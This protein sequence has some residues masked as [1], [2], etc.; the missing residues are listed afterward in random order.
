MTTPKIVA[1]RP[2]KVPPKASSFLQ[3]VS[4]QAEEFM[5]SDLARSGLIPEDLKSY[6]HGQ[7]WVPREAECG[8]VIPYFYPDGQPIVDAERYPAMY[9]VRLKPKPNLPCPRYIQ[10]SKETLLGHGLPSNTPYFPPYERAGN[11]LVICEGEKKTIAAIKHLD[12]P[13]IGIGGCT[14]WNHEWIFEAAKDKHVLIVPDADV[15]RYDIAKQ[16]GSLAAELQRRG[17]TVEIVV[18]PD[19]LD[20]W[21]VS[22]GTREQFDKLPRVDPNS[23]AQ[24]SQQLID[25]YNLTFRTDAKGRRTLDQHTSNIMTLMEKH[26]A[27]PEIW[28]NK[29]NGR[30]YIGEAETQPGLTEMEIANYFQRNLGMDKVSH[31]LIFPVI[32]ALALKNA[33]SPMLD[34][35]NGLVW[36]RRERLD[37]WMIRHW[38]VED[39]EYHRE[40]SSKWLIGS[41]ARLDKAGTK[42]DW[43]LIT[44]GAQ[45]TGKTSM[46]EII[47]RG[48]NIVT[49]GHDGDKDERM[50]LHSALCVGFDE[51]DGFGKREQSS[52][53]AMVTCREDTFRKPYGAAHESHA[54]RSVLYGCGNVVQFLAED[55]SGYRRY[56]VVEVAEILR[57]ADLEGEVE[58]LWAEAWWR[59]RNSDVRYWEVDGASE[60]AQRYVI[61]SSYRELAERAIQRLKK[62]SS[63]S[64]NDLYVAMGLDPG[65]VNMPQAKEIAGIMKS[66]GYEKRAVKIDGKVLKSWMTIESRT[67]AKT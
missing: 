28:E 13:A 52:L 61:E 12:L 41:C 27:F 32:G 9:R 38:G 14:V 10:P 23:L 21:I 42:L 16:Y 20:D 66:L 56:A 45:G 63:F 8:Y 30:V 22:G 54:R 43:M 60:R 35:I 25:Q 40:V 24:S 15:M 50:L 6:S 46:P 19:K 53:K 59:Y 65:R 51:L 37:T 31:R 36:D 58:Q 5:F 62:E 57:F 11:T 48:N 34:W 3:G 67:W 55:N 17:S 2:F 18:P 49:Y 47:F 33:K 39:N 4:K 64:S 7:I 26:P 1:F 44:I 29:D